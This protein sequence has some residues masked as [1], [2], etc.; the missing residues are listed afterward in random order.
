MTTMPTE[1]AGSPDETKRRGVAVE[2]TAGEE[3]TSQRET[4]G[5]EEEQEEEAEMTGDQEMSLAEMTET[6]IEIVM[7][8]GEEVGVVLPAGEVVAMTV[9]VEAT[10]EIVLLAGK[11][12]MGGMMTAPGARG[13]RDEEE[14]TVKGDLTLTV[15]EEEGGTLVGVVIEILGDCVLMT[16]EQVVDGEAPIARQVVRGGVTHRH[17]NQPMRMALK[18]ST[19]GVNC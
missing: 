12:T 17:D 16:T 14:I 11:G 2:G 19:A 15:R 5:E 18:W 3:E 6:E 7:A 4:A 10:M 1:V 8:G 9:P 13:R